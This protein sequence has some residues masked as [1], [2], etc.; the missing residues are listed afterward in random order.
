MRKP[1]SR[2]PIVFA[3]AILLAIAA[4]V[5]GYGRSSTT[6][7]ASTHGEAA[8]SAAPAAESLANGMAFTNLE[9]QMREFMGYD[10][11]IKLTAEQRAIKEEVLGSQAAVC[12][13]DS[14][15][16]ECCCPC[17]LSRSL[18]GLSNYLIAKKGYDAKQLEDAVAKW[19]QF[20]NPAG[21]TGDACYVAGGCE[22]SP[23]AN[24]C[25]GMDASELN[26]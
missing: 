15:A 18:W 4:V 8:P 7:Q 22:R 2:W 10:E 11:S 17:N 12:C 14:T 26:V 24:G 19:M 21:Y 23:R 9:A 16:L 1:V 25:G 3:G 13:H 6:V 5:V 20:S